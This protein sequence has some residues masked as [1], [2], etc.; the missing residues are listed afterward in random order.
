MG[1]E[2]EDE[3]PLME[4]GIDSDSSHHFT[5]ELHSRTGLQLSPTLIYDELMPI[6]TTLNVT[7][8]ALSGLLYLKGL[9]MPSTADAGSSGTDESPAGAIDEPIRPP[10]FCPEGSGFLIFYLFLEVLRCSSMISIS[11]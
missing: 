5:S 8:L 9:Y 2:M 3:T 6:M 4:A 7:A 1:L 11:I 10:L